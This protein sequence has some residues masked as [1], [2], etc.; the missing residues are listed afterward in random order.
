MLAK[1]KVFDWEI[2]GQDRNLIGTLLVIPVPPRSRLAD[3]GKF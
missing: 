1:M 3:L 2:A